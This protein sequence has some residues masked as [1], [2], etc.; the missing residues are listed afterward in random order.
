MGYK[1]VDG[2]QNKNISS[3]PDAAETSTPRLLGWFSRIL[4]LSF[5]DSLRRDLEILCG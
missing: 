4:P 5:F 3:D 2:P 1:L